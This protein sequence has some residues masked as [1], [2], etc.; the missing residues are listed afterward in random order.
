MFLSPTHP[1]RTQ[2][3]MSG[4][5]LCKL[6]DIAARHHLFPFK[7]WPVKSWAKTLPLWRQL[8]T[9]D[10]QGF[11][12]LVHSKTMR[13]GT[14]IEIPN[15][16]DS[17]NTLLGNLQVTMLTWKIK[18][19]SRSEPVRTGQSQSLEICSQYFPNISQ[20]FPTRWRNWQLFRL[21]A[22][23]L[24]EGKGLSGL[25]GFQLILCFFSGIGINGGR[26]VPSANII[27]S[28]ND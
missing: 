4:N 27:P 1:T 5:H 14:E 26:W 16:M 13:P 8:Q 24:S 18:G 11:T 15:T 7:F 28:G 17:F 19:Q 23:E 2:A 20:H 3:I 22:T 10:S 9:P 12:R 25:E 21:W 6:T